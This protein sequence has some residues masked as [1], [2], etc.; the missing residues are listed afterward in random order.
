VKQSN[1]Y[2]FHGSFEA[3]VRDSGVDLGSGDLPVT[4]RSL[5]QVQVTRLLIE[6]SSKGMSQG[7]DR[8]I[9]IDASRFHPMGDAILNLPGREPSAILG[10]EEGRVA[11]DASGFEIST[12]KLQ[13][14]GFEVNSFFSAA[15]DMDGGRLS[16]SINIGSVQRHQGAE[17]HACAIEKRDD[18]EVALG[19]SAFRIFDRLEKSCHLILIKDSRRFSLGRSGFDETRRIRFDILRFQQKGTEDPDS[20]LESIGGDGTSSVAFNCKK[21]RQRRGA[22]ALYLSLHSQPAS[23]EFK[24]PQVSSPGIGA[25]AIGLKLGTKSSYCLIHSHVIPPFSCYIHELIERVVKFIMRTIGIIN[26]GFYSRNCLR[27]PHERLTIA[28]CRAFAPRMGQ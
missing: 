7:M 24:L 20:G 28:H 23:E 26:E 3:A 14:V 4:K 8:S 1:L 12:Q 17:A 9:A 13:E 6:S 5:Y 21:L 22:D 27:K 16:Y 19:S 18:G 25:L 2:Q 10:L 15:F 11:I